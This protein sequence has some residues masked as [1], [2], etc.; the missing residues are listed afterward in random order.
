[1]GAATPNAESKHFV[2]AYE[3]SSFKVLQSVGSLANVVTSRE[4]SPTRL[5]FHMAFSRT[6]FWHGH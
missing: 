3:I 1:M 6:R 4:K 5:Q 2:G